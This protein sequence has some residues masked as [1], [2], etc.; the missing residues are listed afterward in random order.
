M[1]GC[2]DYDISTCHWTIL[3]QLAKRYKIPCPL[4][5]AYV[6]DKTA[7]R[8]RVSTGA[9]ITPDEAKK[10]LTALLFGAKV[11]TTEKS[12]WV[13]P[14]AHVRALGIKAAL[15][16]ARQQDF[17]DMAAEVKRVGQEILATYPRSKGRLINA[18]GV[19]YEP[20]P[21]PKRPS[22][23]KQLAHLLQG[24]EAAA[25]RAVVRRYGRGILLCMHDG[26]VARERLDVAEVCDLIRQET[27]FQLEV[28]EDQ[29]VVQARDRI[30]AK[31]REY[32]AFSEGELDFED[33]FAVAR[34][35]S[36]SSASPSVPLRGGFWPPAGVDHTFLPSE[37]AGLWSAHPAPWVPVRARLAYVSPRPH[38][39]LPQTSCVAAG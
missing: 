34:G 1:A 29:L 10:S 13:A 8:Q 7:L 12:M 32:E 2:W 36:L 19:L 3:A 26:W 6:A 22:S 28:E 9:R 21:T 25:L 20:P 27:G 5:D 14:Q 11:Q 23:S 35:E 17:L 39:N 33:P 38:W 15:R 4:V 16:L 31:L 24:A 37:E 30:K 18:M